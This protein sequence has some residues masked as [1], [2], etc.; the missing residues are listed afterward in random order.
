MLHS[1]Y[2]STTPSLVLKD[3]KREGVITGSIDNQPPMFMPLMGMVPYFHVSFSAG[4]LSLA[5]VVSSQ[6]EFRPMIESP[7]IVAEV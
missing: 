5:F 4:T 7:P 1:V 6:V 2:S 3:E